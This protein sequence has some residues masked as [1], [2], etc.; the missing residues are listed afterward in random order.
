MSTTLNLAVRPLGIAAAMLGAVV[1]LTMLA[2]PRSASALTNCTVADSEVARDAE[3]TAFLALINAFRANPGAYGYSSYPAVGALSFQFGLDRPSAWH[4]H[5]M[6]DLKYFAHNEPGGRTFDKRITDCGYSWSTAGENIVAGGAVDTAQEAFNLWLGSTGHRNNMMTGAFTQIGIARYQGPCPS[7]PPFNGQGTCWYWNTT[8]G[9]PSGSSGGG[10]G[11]TS[12]DVLEFSA[13]SYSGSEGSG[14]ITATINR[15]GNATGSISVKCRPVSSGSTA[16]ATTDYATADVTVS[17]GPGEMQKTCRIPVV[18]DSTV[19]SN[20]TIRLSL[21]SP[22][23]G[24]VIGTRSTTTLTIQD[25]DVA[26]TYSRSDANCDGQVNSTDALLAMRI[27]AGMSSRPAG[28]SQFDPDGDGV[29]TLED[30]LAIRLVAVGLR[31][32]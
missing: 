22:S 16:T 10:G 12:Q 28:C 25:N 3:E 17:F 18:D 2:P 30:V 6:A 4:V 27:V 29:L 26:P 23:T 5:N 7:S 11:G 9:K 32:P 19:E 13:D 20:E 1:L 15:F 24:A 8:F 14:G 21:T 31:Q